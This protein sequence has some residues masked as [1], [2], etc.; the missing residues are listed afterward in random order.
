MNSFFN[1]LGAHKN[2]RVALL[3]AGFV[4]AS[5]SLFMAIVTYLFIQYASLQAAVY[6]LLAL[7]F[8][9][10]IAWLLQQK[11]RRSLW[12]TIV[13]TSAAIATGAIVTSMVVWRGHWAGIVKELLKELSAS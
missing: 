6:L 3:T 4:V 1:Y 12:L 5:V 2:I 10:G 11:T 9:A 7:G 13:V 8:D